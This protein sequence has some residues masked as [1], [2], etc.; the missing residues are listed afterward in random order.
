MWFLADAETY[1]RSTT[2]V[3]L[4]NSAALFRSA[5]SAVRRSL[6]RWSSARK[7]AEG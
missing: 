7:I 3:R 4:P 5:L 1:L 2:N 6:A